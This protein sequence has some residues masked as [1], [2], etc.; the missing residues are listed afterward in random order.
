MLEDDDYLKINGLGIIYFLLTSCIVLLS[1]VNSKIVNNR[2]KKKFG[3]R[4]EDISENKPKKCIET[5]NHI[6][7]MI[8]LL[9][10]IKKDKIKEDL[11]D[12][13]FAGERTKNHHMYL[14]KLKLM[15]WDFFG[16]VLIADYK[17]AIS[18]N[19]IFEHISYHTVRYYIDILLA[20]IYTDHKDILSISHLYDY[21]EGFRRII[22]ISN[23]NYA[24]MKE[25]SN[26]KNN[27]DE[28]YS[29]SDKY[30][31]VI[32]T[33][34]QKNY[35][36]ID[37]IGPLNENELYDYLME[38]MRLEENMR[39]LALSYCNNVHKMYEYVCK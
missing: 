7:N 25:N 19:G 4:F 33:F 31:K 2:P 37:H 35:E 1:I 22:S 29:I 20:G 28:W 36:K 21:I 8:K 5:I 17:F 39:F 10:D 12:N 34:V 15:F 14:T 23:E 30:Y 18:Y 24:L 13:P 9:E 38:R 32:N 16:D 26:M 11:F 27:S 6:E 3:K